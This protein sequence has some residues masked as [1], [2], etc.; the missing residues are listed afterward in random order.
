M[1]TVEL[2]LHRTVLVVEFPQPEFIIWLTDNE[3]LTN[4]KWFF[5]KV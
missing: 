3:R 2:P 4:G 1:H 5:R